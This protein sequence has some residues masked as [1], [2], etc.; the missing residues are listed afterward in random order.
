MICTVRGTKVYYEDVG[1]GR[2]I[3]N[4]HGWPGE[5]G[6]MLQMMEPL[7]GQ[8]QGWRRIY[9]DLPGMGRTPGPDWLTTHD[10]VLD[11]VAELIELTTD[12]EAPLLVGHSY[13][14][15]LVRGLLQRSPDRYAA[16]LLLSPGETET[17]AEPVAPV[18]LREDHAFVAALEEERPFLELFV[19]R[20]LPVLDIVRRQALPGVLSA[21]YDFLGRIEQGPDFSYLH[22]RA[23]PFAGPVLVCSG[24]QDPAGHRRISALLDRY[25]RGTLAIL[26]GAGHLL[27]AEQAELFLHLAGD[28]L[29]RAAQHPAP[30]APQF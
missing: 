3:I 24:R 21:D 19:V 12:G 8:R 5:H 13:G 11:L 4:L 10:Q 2:P 14:A 18:V 15:R 7:F 26:D 9:L 22:E 17:A 28:W 30:A 6:Q 23:T 27:F 16:A 29:D 25:P 20:T 1:Q